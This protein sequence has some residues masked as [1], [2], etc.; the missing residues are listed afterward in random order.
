MLIHF[1]VGSN[2]TIQDLENYNAKIK[3]PLTI[4]MRVKNE[5]FLL[6]SPPPPASGAVLLYMLNLLKGIL[7]SLVPI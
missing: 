7:F 6:Y 2:I 1:V 4:T 5:N 3:A